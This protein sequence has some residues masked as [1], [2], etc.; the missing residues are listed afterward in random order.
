M[1]ASFAACHPVATDSW[2]RPWAGLLFGWLLI[3][4]AV[5]PGRNWQPE[6][7]GLIELANSVLLLL[8][9]AAVA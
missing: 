1:P 9:V 5:L 3:R 8:V 7:V 2:L 6:R 4:A